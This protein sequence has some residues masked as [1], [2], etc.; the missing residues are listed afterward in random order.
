MVVVDEGGRFVVLVGKTC[1]PS[2]PLIV[3]LC[4]RDVNV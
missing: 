4:N 3:M 2:T 1:S